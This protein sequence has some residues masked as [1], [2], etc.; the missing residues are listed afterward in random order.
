MN[1]NI[2]GNNYTIMVRPTLLYG[3]EKWGGVTTGIAIADCSSAIQ[4]I[5]PISRSPE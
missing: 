3:Q 1:V 2:N 5:H 4:I